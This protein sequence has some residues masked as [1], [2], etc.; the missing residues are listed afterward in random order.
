MNAPLPLAVTR[1]NL[2]EGER[3]LQRQGQPDAA[4]LA[5]TYRELNARVQALRFRSNQD[6][7]KWSAAVKEHEQMIQALM[8]RD[9]GA[10]KAVL[11][12]HLQHKRDSVLELMRAGAVYPAA[13]A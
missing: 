9:G 6:R 8:A 4:L 1:E 5:R 13:K 2:A 11:L 12:D 7:V 10:L 3:T